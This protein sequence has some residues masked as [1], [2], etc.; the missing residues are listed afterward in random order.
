MV[1]IPDIKSIVEELIT[2][3]AELSGDGLESIANS[4]AGSYGNSESEGSERDATEDVGTSFKGIRKGMGFFLSQ[5]RQDE[6][7]NRVANLPA[8]RTAN[9]ETGKGL[10]TV[11]IQA[12]YTLDRKRKKFAVEFEFDQV[13]EVVREKEAFVAD[14]PTFGFCVGM[15]CNNYVKCCKWNF[16]GSIIATSSQDRKIRFFKSRLPDFSEME[17]QKTASLGSLIYDICWHP[18]ADCLATSSKD[19]PIHCWD[20]QGKRIFSFRGINEQD[21]LDSAQALCF[22]HDGLH[23]YGGY[24]RLIRIFD[25][26]RPGRQQREIKTWVKESGGQK[27]VITCITMNPVMHGVYAAASYGK[28][29][30]LYSDLTSSVE[31]LFDTSSNGITHIRYSNDG[32]LLFA[33]GRKEDFITCWDLRFPGR[34]LGTLERPCSTNQ[35]LYFEIDSCNRYLFTGDSSGHLRVFDLSFLGLE[36]LKPIYI[37]SAYRSTLSGISIHPNLP[38]IATCSGQRIFPL[39]NLESEEEDDGQSQYELGNGA[40]DLDNSL[41]LWLF[42]QMSFPSVSAL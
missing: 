7:G 19:H 28:S 32:N 3:V 21:E 15:Q 38:L 17:L 34:V 5:L 25:V 29:I 11:H 30:G 27:A 8:K 40:I 20:Q 6:Q 16:D 24:R 12:P 9:D 23:L 41:S 4:S 42:S 37:A 39:P 13:K 36:S 22:S 18:F 26:N 31:C 1:Y 2:R 10:S 35:R 14:A 33:A